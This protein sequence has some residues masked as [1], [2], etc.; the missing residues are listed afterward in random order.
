[1]KGCLIVKAAKIKANEIAE[2]LVET[3]GA[4]L[5]SQRSLNESIVTVAE[6]TNKLDIW[7]TAFKYECLGIETA[8]G[9][10]DGENEAIY[11]A[12]EKMDQRMEK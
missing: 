2:E 5:I 8:Y 12:N 7:Q 11:I 4:S 6:I 9:F 3:F 10:A 1:M